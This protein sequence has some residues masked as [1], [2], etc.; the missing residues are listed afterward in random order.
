VS[1]RLFA[2]ALLLH[3]AADGRS[4][5]EIASALHVA[6]SSVP[7]YIQRLNRA[8]ADAFGGAEIK[9][10]MSCSTTRG[11]GYALAVPPTRQLSTEP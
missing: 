10:A 6:P 9:V 5:A 8:V 3:E 11:S 7:K 2:L 4:V 1:E